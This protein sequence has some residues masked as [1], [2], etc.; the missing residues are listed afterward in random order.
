MGALPRL[1]RRACQAQV[2]CWDP[3]QCYQLYPDHRAAGLAKLG[4]V[5]AAGNPH[6]YSDLLA[7][8]VEAY[9]MPEVYLFGAEETGHLGGHH[10]HRG[11][12]AGCQRSPPQPEWAEAGSAWRGTG[13]QR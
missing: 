8:G 6:Y 5:P 13:L 9:P 7:E 3:W 2:L 12:E 4:A 10:C 1:I 11:A